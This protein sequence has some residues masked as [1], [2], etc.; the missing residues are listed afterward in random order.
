MKIET[1]ILRICILSFLILYQ[2]EC[3]DNW[4][5]EQKINGYYK[6]SYFGT[7][8]VLFE[9]NLV[10]GAENENNSRGAVY[11]FVKNGLDYIFQ[12]K[13]NC[14]APPASINQFFGFALDLQNSTLVVGAYGENSFQ[15]AIYIFV[16]NGNTWILQ[17]RFNDTLDDI[18]SKQYYGYAIAL[19]APFLV[20][21][22]PVANG[23]GAV[24]IYEQIGN[25]WSLASILFPNIYQTFGSS[26]SVNGNYLAVG[27]PWDLDNI[28][29][30]VVYYYNGIN[31]TQQAKLTSN[32]RELNDAFGIYLENTP[33]IL[34]VG[35]P[36][37]TVS[38]NVNQGSVYVFNRTDSSNWTYVQTVV[39]SDGN[40]GDSFGFYFDLYQNTMI[41]GSFL[42]KVSNQSNSGSA[43]IYK[44][45]GASW[46]E[47][48]KLQSSDLVSGD[49]FGYSVS[50]F[51]NTIV[52][53]SY[54]EKAEG[55][56]NSG[57]AYVFLN[58]PESTTMFTLQTTN[59]ITV[60]ASSKLQSSV[61]LFIIFYLFLFYF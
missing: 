51:G 54:S 36:Y 56:L 48:E 2:T 17:D 35:V 30:V 43:Y 3:Q 5:Q 14:Y 28:G 37:D 50:I 52:S 41:V 4:V 40:A 45:V 32:D 34:L 58:L 57:A 8:T 6:N 22:A 10:V 21:G 33:N 16:W 24:F 59:P 7:S 39:A 12:Q 38:N 25:S 49:E 42:S 61:F 55:L 29:K 44:Q 46:F 11:L 18:S 13:I 19:Y 9:N 53:T 20:V 26:V 27:A 60:S 31:W 47:V 15:G 1:D 23:K